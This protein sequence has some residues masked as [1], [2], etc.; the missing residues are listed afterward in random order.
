MS[1]EENTEIT[2]PILKTIFEINEG[3]VVSI[4]G[5]LGDECARALHEV[6]QK[7]IDPASGYVLESM[8]IDQQ[9]NKAIL[10]SVVAEKDHFN[11]QDQHYT[12]VYVTDPVTIT[13]VDLID[14]KASANETTNDPDDASD[15]VVYVPDPVP[16]TEL[17]PTMQVVEQIANDHN[18]KIIYGVESLAVHLKG[19]HK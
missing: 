14:F 19:M 7:D 1:H 6:Y 10:D 11:Q 9:L 16:G 18:V 12:L 4:K 13:P 15:M 3:H 2:H 8:Q 17:S 5:A